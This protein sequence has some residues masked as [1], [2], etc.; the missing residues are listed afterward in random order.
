MAN[1]YREKIDINTLGASIV[2][3]A[4]KDVEWLEVPS[5][6]EFKYEKRD[7]SY[8][9]SPPEGKPGFPVE[10]NAADVKNEG[11][12][13]SIRRG[14][15][16]LTMPTITEDMCTIAGCVYDPDCDAPGTSG[17]TAATGF[18]V[19]CCGGGHYGYCAGVW[20]CP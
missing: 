12:V 3:K 7:K 5:D 20:G 14:A 15:K 17:C 19:I 9:F 2:R 4:P 8:V 11:G 16:P 18:L 10:I 6:I 13:L 1:Q